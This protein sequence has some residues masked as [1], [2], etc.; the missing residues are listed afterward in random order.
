MTVL[1]Y[2]LSDVGM[3]RESNE[4]CYLID[5]SLGLYLVCDGM[6]G[7]EGGE[8]AAQDAS[9]AVQDYFNKHAGELAELTESGNVES[10]QNLVVRAVQHACQ[11][12]RSVLAIKPIGFGS[13]AIVG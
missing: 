11:T 10:I 13:P 4:D 1:A 7:H 6:G 8:I 12:H 5:E 2:G 9:K 3:R